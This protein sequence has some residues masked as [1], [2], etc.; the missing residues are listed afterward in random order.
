MGRRGLGEAKRRQEAGVRNKG[1][2]GETG[3]RRGSK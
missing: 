2:E 1:T 3:Q